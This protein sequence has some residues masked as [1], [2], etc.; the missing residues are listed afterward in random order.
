[1][2]CPNCG[3]DMPEN[4][5]YCEKCGEDI[6]II[7]D[8]EPEVER[9]L[10]S[11]ISGIAED[12]TL[13]QKEIDLERKLKKQRQH[14]I[15]CAFLAGAVV[16]YL[17]F[18]IGWM[19]QG[20]LAEKQDQSK[21]YQLKKARSCAQK[22]DYQE[23]VLHYE[24]ALALDATDVA[25]ELELADLYFE[26]NRKRDYEATLKKVLE[27]QDVSFEQLSSTYGKLIA[28]YRTREDFQ[29]IY[30]MLID[31]GNQ[32]IIEEFADFIPPDPIFSLD[33]GTYTSVQPLKLTADKS[34]KIYYT[35]DGDEPG[36]SSTPYTAP[37]ILED[38][39]HSVKACTVNSYGAVSRYVEKK[40]HIDVQEIEAPVVRP[41]SGSYKNPT[42]I[43]ID[44]TT[45]NVYYTT[46]GSKPNEDAYIYTEPIPMP[47]GKTSFKFAQVVNGKVGEITEC[48]YDLKLDTD[49]TTD[50]A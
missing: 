13:Q 21:E 38:G 39:D 12:V 36:L 50:Q 10:Q 25:V 2:K 11:I 17:G 16:I 7:P 34:I 5:L 47:L 4:S 44:N 46:D 40:Y 30:D 41:I 32:K 28:L 43:E 42:F 31:C 8:F 22:Q 23:A 26:Q 19:L 45:D 24:K 3:S 35:L 14:R 33:S 49:F 6:H 37:I 18:M 9:N 1:M 27:M 48:N 15:A 20:I 29:S